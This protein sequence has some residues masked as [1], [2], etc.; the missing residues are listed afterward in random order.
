[1]DCKLVTREANW[2]VLPVVQV[3]NEV[4][5]HESGSGESGFKRCLAWRIILLVFLMAGSFIQVCRESLPGAPSS[6][7]PPCS[8][9]RF[10]PHRGP[11]E[12]LLPSPCYRLRDGEVTPAVPHG[13][14]TE[15]RVLAHGFHGWA[16]VCGVASWRLRS[17]SSQGEVVRA[18]GSPLR[19]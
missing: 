9:P 12:R 19:G 8:T 10:T 3:G 1:M 13:Q 14:G 17:H 4:D 16:L 6:P 18:C 11:A 5:L 15:D 7:S 2:E